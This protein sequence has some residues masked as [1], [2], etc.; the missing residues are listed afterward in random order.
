[1]G[2][3]CG[4]GGGMACALNANFYGNGT[5]TLVLSHGFGTDQTV[6]HYLIP[7][8]ACYFKVLVFDLAFTP[9][10]NST[11]YDSKKYSNFDGYAHDLVSLLDE[12]N[13]NK[14]IYVG[15]SMSAMIG[16]IAA[17]RKPQLFE[18]L[19]LLG[20]SPRYQNEEGY[21]GGFNEPKLD[22][23]F[24]SIS[25]NFSKWAHSFAPD[26]VGV[27]NPSAVS[28][29]EHSLL[30]MNP[31][32][33]LEV[34]K[35]IFLSDLRTILPQV[36]VPCTIIQTKNDTIV[37]VSVASY[38]KKNLGTHSEVKILQTQGH[39]PQLTAYCLLLKVLR[40]SLFVK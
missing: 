27:N 24:E 7:F 10:V 33:A 8:L 36:H 1:M 14:T 18:H 11:L 5:Q 19:V 21:E 4:Y 29:F 30:R 23:I 34:A 16:C 40:D 20:G 22:E 3:T 2:T 15:H 32:I 38:M 37:P 9:N 31:S 13:L 17:T 28:E 6:W 12:L 26:A 39:F 25:K 35:T